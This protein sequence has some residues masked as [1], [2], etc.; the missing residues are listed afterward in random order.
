[1]VVPAAQRPEWQTPLPSGVAQVGRGIVDER[2]A[3]FSERER[4]IVELLAGE[5]HEVRAAPTAVHP[6][7]DA[8]VDA[9]PMEWKSLGTGATMV[10]VRNASGREK[11]QA[12]DVFI[13][14]RGCGLSRAQA[15]RGV[16]RFVASPY[17]RLAAIRVVGDFTPDVRWWRER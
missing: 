11:K 4:A 8:Y 5:G 13:D 17:N 6:T 10:T 15:Q 14:A 7:P 9:R 1:V 16:D 12:T 2:A 3:R